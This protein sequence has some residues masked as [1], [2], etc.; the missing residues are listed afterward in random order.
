MAKVKKF[1]AASLGLTHNPDQRIPQI[2]T[3]DLEL[4]SLAKLKIEVVSDQQVVLDHTKA[5]EYLDLPI[6]PGE[7]EITESHCQFLYDEMRKGTFNS[8]LVILST[9]TLD[10]IRYKING[11]HTCWAVL[12][13]PP[14]YSL[15]VREIAY[16]V[17][18]REQLKLLYG[19]YDR[20]RARSDSH[21]T[22]V[23]LADT[24]LTEGLWMSEVP[25]LVN[26]FRHWH[27]TAD[28]ASRRVSPEQLAATIQAGFTDVFRAVAGFV[29]ANH[30]ASPLVRRTAVQAAMFATFHKLPTKAAEFWQPVADG[31]NLSSKTDPRYVLRDTLQ[32]LLT[33]S[34]TT[35]GGKGVRVVTAEDQYRLCILAW[36]K[37]RSGEQARGALRTPGDRP[38]VQ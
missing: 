34:S 13:M 14:S 9:A 18:S 38:R 10:G 19:T 33:V 15:R 4:A 16:R 32:K 35:R 36:N 26:A 30:K 31:I 24:P 1:D 28:T 2:H 20:L 21:V 22:K 37:W 7:R 6:F 27:I 5:V 8:L 29:Q 23:F 11:Q 3:D 12:A 17:A 25:R